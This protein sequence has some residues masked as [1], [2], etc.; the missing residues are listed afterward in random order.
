M[1]PILNIEGRTEEQKIQECIDY[2]MSSGHRVSLPLQSTNTIKTPAGLVKFFY[3]CLSYYS[4]SLTL[5]YTG[6][7][8]KDLAIAK[9]FISSRI[10][11]GISKARATYEC[12]LLIEF[13][14][15]YENCL[16][17]KTKVTSMSVLGQDKMAWFTHN[18]ID[19]YNGFNREVEEHKEKI[20]F[21]NF[22]D[23]QELSIS[24][25]QVALANRRIGLGDENGEESS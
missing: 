5:M 1:N 11:T 20:W 10:T 7:K 13:L 18:L 6:D 4:T 19:A 2:L 12:C 15:K 9:K 23:K 17:L 8:K 24:E 16:G 22:Y 21:E 3:N 25:E 14:F